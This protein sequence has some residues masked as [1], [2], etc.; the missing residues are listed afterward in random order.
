[1]HSVRV[2]HHWYNGMQGSR[3]L[4]EYQEAYNQLKQQLTKERGQR[5]ELRGQLQDRQ[6]QLDEA[7]LTIAAH[8]Q[9]E[10]RHTAELKAVKAEVQNERQISAEL[11]DQLDYARS[12]VQAE[13]QRFTQLQAQLQQAS[14]Q[15]AASCYWFT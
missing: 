13:Q 3:Y 7:Q 14:P 11:Q 1:L 4:A 12:E 9:A 5:E 15:P 8:Q 2:C 10:H 6:R